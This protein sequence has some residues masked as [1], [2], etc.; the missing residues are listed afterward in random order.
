AEA[1]IGDDER[2]LREEGDAGEKRRTGEDKE[3]Q[4][5]DFGNFHWLSSHLWASMN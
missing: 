5:S 2:L 4:L 3:E 1:Y